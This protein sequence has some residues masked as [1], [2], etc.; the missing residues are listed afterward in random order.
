MSIRVNFLILSFC[1]NQVIKTDNLMPI[2]SEYR[3]E[4]KASNIYTVKP[5]SIVFV[6]GL[7]KKQW[8]RENN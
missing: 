4:K 7:K 5:L 8:I 2:N 3:M 1:V 6:G